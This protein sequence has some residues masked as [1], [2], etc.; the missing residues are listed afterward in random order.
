MSQKEQTAHPAVIPIGNRVSIIRGKNSG[1][2]SYIYDTGT[3][4]GH[5]FYYVTTPSSDIV[6]INQVFPD[7]IDHK[8]SYYLKSKAEQIS[9]GT[10][11][12]HQDLGAP[13]IT[14]KEM[15]N[16][17]PP[18]DDEFSWEVIPPRPVRQIDHY[19]AGGEPGQFR[20][21][22]GDIRERR[23]FRTGELVAAQ[24]DTGIEYGTFDRYLIGTN[25][26]VAFVRINGAARIFAADS[27]TRT[28]PN[29]YPFSPHD[30]AVERPEP[31][32]KQKLFQL[33]ELMEIINQDK[34]AE[35]IILD[36]KD[37]LTN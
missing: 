33:D 27:I 22:P 23:S 34:S 2:N 25:N 35:E 10:I 30:K 37:H 5:F 11:R 19:V 28:E 31:V 17:T 36:L 7:N 8:R 26:M 12:E 15:S 24:S 20:E 9:S 3:I 32:I 13:L 29:M 18:T 1:F 14:Q 6:H 21:S 16:N 4:N